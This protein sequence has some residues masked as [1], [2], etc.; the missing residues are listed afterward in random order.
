VTNYALQFA[1]EGFEIPDLPFGEH[2]AL[3]LGAPTDQLE[4]LRKIAVYGYM[5]A[6]HDMNKTT[7]QEETNG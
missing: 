5:L 3:A 6:Q 2:E 7:T 4:A 1:A